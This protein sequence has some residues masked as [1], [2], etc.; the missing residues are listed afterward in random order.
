MSRIGKVPRLLAAIG[1][2]QESRFGRLGREFGKVAFD[3][4]TLRTDPT[5]EWVTPG[6]P[7]F[8]AVRTEI[9]DRTVD[10]LRR[11]AV[12]YDL[13][14]K[15]PALWDVFA[16]SVKDGRGSTLHRRMFVVETALD[17]TSTIRQPTALHDVAPAPAGVAVPDAPL[18]TRQASESAL[19]ANVLSPWLDETA[20]EREHEVTRVAEHVEI[21]LKALIHR[22]QL[23]LAD[24][25][26][27]QE[28]GKTVQGLDGIIAQADQ[29]LPV[30]R[31][32]AG[33]TQGRGRGGGRHEGRRDGAAGVVIS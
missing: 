33:V 31:G 25:L 23:Q 1:D 32:A 4:E 27:R 8:E 14:R 12:F 29:Q 2:K 30:Q 7:L 17:G 20:K 16:A 22:Q 11:G 24:F 5:L 21:S 18:P 26:S 28:E 9:G 15:E 19:Y 10:D 6:H 13:H 3:K